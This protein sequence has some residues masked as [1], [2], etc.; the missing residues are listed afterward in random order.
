VAKVRVRQ[1]RPREEIVVLAGTN[2]AGKSSVAGAALT[3]GDTEFYNPDEA[4]RR[5]VAAG[6]PVDEANARAWDEGRRLLERA[7]R[8]RLNFAFE[9]TLGGHTMTALLLEA[10]KQGLPVRIF[11]VGLA[12]PELHIQRVR[13]RVARGGHD[14]PEH[15]IRARWEASRENLI[16][17]LPHVAELAVWDN[18]AEA[19][20]EADEVPAPVRILLM[21][22]RTIRDLYP[23]DQV[24]TWAKPIVAAALGCDPSAATGS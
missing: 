24:P 5:Y 7:I 14:I 18:S 17:L 3:Q 8:E 12:S 23:L 20:P 10:T 21:Q 1:A 2:G 16:R 19:D 15:K 11:Y 4:T 22:D 6:L 9:T 13:E